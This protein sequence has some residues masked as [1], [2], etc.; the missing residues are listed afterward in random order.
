MQEND[1]LHILSSMIFSLFDNL[2]W[3]AKSP[4]MHLLV[5]KLNVANKKTQLS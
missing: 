3:A 5:L 4:K 1:I 2:T